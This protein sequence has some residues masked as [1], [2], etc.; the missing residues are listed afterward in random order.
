MEKLKFLCVICIAAVAFSAGTRGQ[1]RK[2][3][4]LFPVR[5]KGKW[6]YIN[7]A[8]KI[9]IKPQFDDADDF[10]DGLASVNKGRNWFYINSAGKEVLKGTFSGSEWSVG[11]G[12]FSEGLAPAP[13]ECSWG[14][15]NQAGETIV[16]PQFYAA[17]K[18]SEGLASATPRNSHGK[19]GYINHEG[20]FV[21]EPQFDLAED[22][23]DGLAAVVID[24]RWGFI[25]RTGRYVI[26]L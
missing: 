1:N 21:I 3:D 23:S 17:G 2:A 4:G 12:A 5:V 8:G 9:V 15:I 10:S 14:Y 22:F 24:K 19:S 16:E 25:D 26:N 18:F 11:G 6:G 7:N 20:Q 13:F